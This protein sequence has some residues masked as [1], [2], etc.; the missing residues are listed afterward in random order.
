MPT[1]QIKLRD[2]SGQITRIVELDRADD[3]AAIAELA[4]HDWAPDGGGLE[5]WS[6]DR[7]IMVGYCSSHAAE[8]PAA[9]R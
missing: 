4:L 2:E 9:V 5:L 6:G 1:Y 3:S 8:P 7:C